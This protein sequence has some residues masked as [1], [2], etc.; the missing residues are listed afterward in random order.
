MDVGGKTEAREGFRTRGRLPGKRSLSH[1]HPPFPASQAPGSWAYATL[2]QDARR[3]DVIPTGAVGAV[4]TDLHSFVHA[5]TGAPSKK[6]F[7]L[8]D[9]VLLSRGS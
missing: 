1:A 7:S 4:K 8:T 2:F 6:F 3:I 5:L 9:Q